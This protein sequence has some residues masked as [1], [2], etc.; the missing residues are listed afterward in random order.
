MQSRR[1]ILWALTAL[2]AS[3]L[4]LAAGCK[5]EAP[6]GKIK[7]TKV[8]VKVDEVAH[9]ELLL[10][11]NFEGVYREIWKVEPPELGEVYFNQAELKRREA[12]FHSKVAGKGKIVVFGFYGDAKKPYRLASVPLT[13]E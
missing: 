6:I 4:P 5:N 2:L 13:V 7:P 12:T 8:E 3:S 9:L 10:S 11:T 1:T